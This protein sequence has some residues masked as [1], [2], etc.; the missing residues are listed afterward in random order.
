MPKVTRL[1]ETS[2]RSAVERLHGLR[3]SVR[4][5]GPW[6]IRLTEQGRGAAVPAWLKVPKSGAVDGEVL[7]I[8]RWLKTMVRPVEVLACLDLRG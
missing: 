6:S 5:H 1:I 7:E 4:E 2:N 3:T 8:A